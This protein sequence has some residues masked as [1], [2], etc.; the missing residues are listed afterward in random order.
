MKPK[1]VLIVC[2]GNICRSPMAYGLLRAYLQ[3][4]GLD[5][6]IVVETAGTHALVNEPPSAPGQKILAERGIDISHHRARQVTPQLL[7]DADVVLVMEEAH[8]RSLF[9]LAPQHLGKILLLSELVGEHQDVEDPYGQPE[10]MYRKTAALLDRYI[11]EGFPTLLKH[12]GMEH[13][14]QASTPDPG[15]EPMA[16]PLEPFK[17]KAVEPIP[18]LTREEREAYLRE[19]GLNVFNLPSRAVTIDLLTDSG[20]GAM[21]A[22]QWAALH[23]GDE[24][25]AGARSY[26]HLAEAQAEIFGFPY[27][28]P[29]H[30]GR[31]AERVLF[32]IL[33]QPGDVV[34]TNQPFDTTL[35]NIEARGARALELVIEEAYDTTLDHPFKGNIDLERLERHLQGDPKPSFVLLTITNNTGGGQPVS[36]ENMRQVRALCDRYGVP[37]FLDAARHAENAYF[38]KEREAPHLSIREIVRETFALAD[39]MLMSAKKDGLVNIGGLLAVRDK[40]LFDRITQNMVRTEGFPTY[41]GLAGRDMEALAWGLREAVDEAYLR[42]RIGQ[43]RYLAHRLREEGV[44]IVEPPGGHAVYIDILRLLPDWPREHLPGLAF[45]LALYR[46]GGIRAAELGT[47]AF[48]RRDPETGEWIF[49]RLELVRLAIPRRVYTQSHMDYVA[50]VIAH[51]AREKETLLRPVRIVEEPPALRHFLARFAEDVPSPGTD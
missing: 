19:A 37:L 45:T 47:V 26:E 48:G 31:A 12:L 24:A 44:P 46:E 40:A 13:Q 34:A 10:E 14:E 23:L 39:G 30:Q 33:L 2:T 21:S 43:V 3:E 22:Q 9:Y 51:V 28:T 35:A 16:H 42:Y 1:R 25:Y 5:Q 29:V 18:L 17:I 36:L 32:E 4:Q 20:T 49:P 50:D 6:A 11:R 15:G 38:I 27:F 7:R 8:R 41:G